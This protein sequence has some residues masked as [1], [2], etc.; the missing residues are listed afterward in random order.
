MFK[1]NLLIQFLIL[2]GIMALCISP[3]FSQTTLYTQ[4]FADTVTGLPTGWT[5][6]GTPLW[7]TS[8]NQPSS[9]YSGASGGRNAYS[10]N[11]TGANFLTFQ[12]NLST[13]NYNNITV[14]WGARKD[15]LQ[16]P[17]TFQWSTNGTTWNNVAFTDANPDGIWALVNGGTRIQLPAGAQ[18]V[19]NLQFRWSLT[20]PVNYRIDDFSVQGTLVVGPAYKLVITSITDPGCYFIRKDKP[21][22]VT[23]QSQ[24]QNG[25]PSNVSQQTGITLGVSSG[26][27]NLSGNVNGTINA[28][29]NSVVLS[30]VLYNTAENNVR[31]SAT[32]VIGDPLLAGISSPF[33][34]HNNA[35]QIGY[36]NITFPYNGITNNIINAFQI[37]G[38]IPPSGYD[39]CFSGLIKLEWV[40]GPTN[41]LQGT[42]T[43]NASG[44]A[45]YFNDIYFNQSGTYTIKA[46]CA[47]MSD[48]MLGPFN[49]SDGTPTLTEILLPQY[50]QGQSPTN[51]DRMPYVYLAELSNLGA[52]KTYRYYNKV[53]VSGDPSNSDG[54]GNV[55]FAKTSGFTRTTTPD[56]V[57]IGNY[58]E[59]TTNI[60]GKYRGWFITEPTDDAARFT[61]G[62]LVKMNIMLNDGN[63]GQSV[64][65]R[66]RTTNTVKVIQFGVAPPNGAVP[67]LQFT[68]P[69]ANISPKNFLMFYTDTASGNWRPVAGTMIESDGLDV[70]TFGYNYWYVTM[71][72]GQA[73]KWGTIIPSNLS[74]G[75]VRIEERGIIQAT[76]LL[77][78]GDIVSVATA[79]NGVWPPGVDTKNQ[80]SSTTP[81]YILPVFNLIGITKDKD[82]VPVAY[83]LMQNYPNPF[84]PSTIIKFDI[85]K[86]SKVKLSIYDVLG[87]EIS[88]LIDE[89]LK[90]GTYSAEVVA[91]DLPTGVYF[92]KLETDNFVETKKMLLIK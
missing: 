24:D 21:F 80:P 87:K 61:P 10:G 75:I 78:V 57:T 36:T 18:G 81:L 73:N 86:T 49:I 91:G 51:N 83:H 38:V 89:E 33:D 74:G 9:G 14:I 79:P 46:T 70:S 66:L 7:D 22:S 3:I 69:P 6:S 41:G 85:P 50:I 60:Y 4:S 54:V 29:F 43:K 23:V 67:F 72:D 58:G 26:S 65:L 64:S 90:T 55:I 34:V 5:S 45:A 13:V 17:I 63:N 16:G 62:T 77:A 47:G 12:N 2:A 35:S 48:L 20:N 59:F 52:N 8:P 88:V 28:G 56:F 76:D 19:S 37:R 82:N 42:L 84:N 15:A 27:G 1:R 53:V 32:V 30:G 25:Y 40:S 71:V 44:G 39:S 92:Y 11:N 31:I 68:P